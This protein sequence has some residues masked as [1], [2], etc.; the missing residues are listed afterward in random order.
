MLN[1]QTKAVCSKFVFFLCV[2]VG[3]GGVVVVVESGAGRDELGALEEDR[4]LR[5]RIALGEKEFYVYYYFLQ[6]RE[7]YLN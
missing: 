3:R 7:I 1:I 4:W 2:C 6:R 5:N